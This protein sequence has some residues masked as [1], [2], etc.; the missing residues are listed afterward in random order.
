MTEICGTCGLEAE[1]QGRLKEDD[2]K[3]YVCRKCDRKWA[4]NE[5]STTLVGP[6]STE[7]DNFKS[8]HPDAKA[9]PKCGYKFHVMPNNIFIAYELRPDGSDFCT[10]CQSHSSGPNTEAED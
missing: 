9:C 5:I 3:V 6:T 7:I 1:Y 2:R 4:K 8:M 10:V